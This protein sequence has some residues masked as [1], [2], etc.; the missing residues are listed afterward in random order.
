MSSGMSVARA[1][2]W[3]LP[4]RFGHAGAAAEPREG[5]MIEQEFDITSRN[6]P[7]SSF[8]VCPDEPG[9]FPAIILYMDAPGIREELRNL[10]RR[11]AKEGYFCLLPDLYYRLGT[12]RFDMTRAAEGRMQTIFAAMNSLTNKLVADDTAA[13]LGWLDAE[14][15]ARPGPV[16]IIGY[17]M[18]GKFVTTVAARYPNRVAASASLYGVG[19]VTKEA[20]SPHLLVPKIKG[21]IYYGFAE[22]DPHVAPET[23]PTLT[24]ALK[25]AGTRHTI[26]VLPGTKHGYQFPEREVYDPEAAEASW[27]KIFAMW[28]EVLR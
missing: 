22:D 23:I 17:C 24:D 6:G 28:D 7:I 8:A 19:I 1:W 9:P 15:H 11:I 2:R 12:L 5:L 13:F 4:G 26:E 16:G 20:D 25:A 10:A 14:E 18:S 21:A 27:A 3:I